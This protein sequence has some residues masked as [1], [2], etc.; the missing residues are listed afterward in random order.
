MLIQLIEKINIGSSEYSYQVWLANGT[1][2]VLLRLFRH[3]T[4][5]LSY[6]QEI[7]DLLN[8]S[9]QY[10]YEKIVLDVCTKEEL[11]ERMES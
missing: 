4:E 11:Y 1:K 7:A 3:G 8:C 2:S 6:T 10:A 9:T 5:A